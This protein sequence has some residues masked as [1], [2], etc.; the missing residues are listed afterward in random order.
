[1]IEEFLI[2]RRHVRRFI[3]QPATFASFYP[4]SSRPPKSHRIISFADP[5]P[6]TLFK[7]YRSKNRGRGPLRSFNIATHLSTCRINTSKSVSKQTTLS[8][9]RM[10]TYEKQ[11]RG[12]RLLLTR[13]P[14]K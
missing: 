5:H 14:T 1:M 8:S 6:L 4:L 13:N 2:V 12:G 7:S 10:N 11:G 3:L 9:F